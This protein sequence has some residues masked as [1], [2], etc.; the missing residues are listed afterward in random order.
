MP[1]ME[2]GSKTVAH[3]LAKTSRR[4]CAC[5][6][7]PFRRLRSPCHSW[8]EDALETMKNK[9]QFAKKKKTKINLDCGL[10]MINA[11]A[12][13]IDVGY[14]EHW[15]AV[16]A[17]RCDTPVRRFGTFTED[18][19]AMAQWFKECGIK[20]VVMEST[21]VYW[22]P[23]FQ[24]LEREGFEVRL[25]NA[26]QVKNVSGRKTDVLDCQWLQRLHSYGLLRGSFRP[27]DEMCVLR[28]YLRYRDDLV[29]AR[30]T[31]CLHMQ[32]ALQQ[33]NVQL[34]QVLSDITGLSGMRIIEAILQGERDPQKLAAMA[35]RRVRSSRETIAKALQGDY[36]S[37]HLFVLKSA[38]ELHAMYEK[39]IHVCDEQVI[40][41]MAK[42]P[43]RADP[44]K[45]LPARK[46][47]RSA[48]SDRVAGKDLREELYRWTG[49]DLTAVEGI[50]V[51][52]AQVILSE[53]GT[54]MGRW[55][56][57]KHFTSWLG[58]CP[59][60][61][62]S[63]GKVLSSHTRQVVNPVADTLRIAATTLERSQTALGAFYR[64]MKAKLGSASAITATAHKL[65]RVIYRL[66]K[67]GELYVR[68]GMEIYEQRY[69]ER[70]LYNLRR[71]AKRLGFE[72]TQTE[73]VN[74][75]VS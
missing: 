53:I 20:T 45:T 59:D 25:V 63:G 15:C 67:H 21:G 73:P 61:R 74:A 16:P 23:A 31:Q 37:E 33:M 11:D 28:S 66:L 51:L 10:E 60:N 54:D 36:R 22:I 58:L 12:A 17:R 49:V 43:T 72:L 55:R 5:W 48:S 47:G 34:H 8:A 50:G 4:R 52:S 70:L 32:K 75:C 6:P 65:A 64:R 30:S 14:R 24:V 9:A 40:A 7:I 27:A 57:E 46:A 71:N 69:R 1:V 35:D 44:Q 56:S 2:L 68:Q 29:C 39:Q 42:L 26:R 13:G 62:I 3:P 38:F 41:E 19:Q 18:L